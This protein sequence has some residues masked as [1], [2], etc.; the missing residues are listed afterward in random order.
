[1]RA[2][3]PVWSKHI[4]GQRDWQRPYLLVRNDPLAFGLRILLWSL[5]PGLG[6]THTGAPRGKTSHETCRTERALRKRGLPCSSTL[7]VF[8]VAWC[9]LICVLLVSVWS[10][11]WLIP[12]FLG[13]WIE[14][15]EWS[16]P[17]AE[18]AIKRPNKLTV[19]RDRSL[20]SSYFE[21]DAATW[22]VNLSIHGLIS[23]AL[24]HLRIDVV[25]FMRA[26]TFPHRLDN[27]SCGFQRK[28]RVFCGGRGGNVMMQNSF[29]GRLNLAHLWTSKGKTGGSGCSPA[30]LLSYRG[31]LCESAAALR[32]P[33]ACV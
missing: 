8:K 5:T 15:Q 25:W 19:S 18:A 32:V 27:W 26:R 11:R 20:E 1:M 31:P 30:L 14:M 7:L 24:F 16:Y 6:K 4:K 10:S 9:D 3:V 28:R 29:G 23:E 33:V 17:S 12:L 13:N 2:R 21:Q 22:V